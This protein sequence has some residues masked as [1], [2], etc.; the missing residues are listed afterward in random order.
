MKRFYGCI[1]DDEDDGRDH[2]FSVAAPDPL[3]LTNSHALSQWFPPPL[4][5]GSYGTCTAHG[6]TAALRYDLIVNDL[7][8]LLLSRSQP[9]WD[10]GVIEGDTGDVGRQIRDMLTAI[11]TKGAALESDWGYDKIGQQP[12]PEVYA[13]ALKHLAIEYCRVPVDRLSINTAIFVGHPVIIGVPVFQSFESDEVAETGFV[14]MPKTGEMEV[15]LHCMLLGDY[16]P[17]YDT[18]LNSWGADWGQSGFC[19]IPRGYLEKYGSD[20]WAIL[21]NR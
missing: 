10:A 15:G 2:K 20:F 1:R 18:I 21:I 4:N 13:S 6:T 19:K 8:D 5:Q 9:Y 17:E 3:V 7:P 12:P 11:A 14:P 16:D